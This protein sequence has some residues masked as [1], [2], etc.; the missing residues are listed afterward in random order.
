MT[1]PRGL[2]KATNYWNNVEAWRD[3]KAL[4]AKAVDM[5]MAEIVRKYEPT[6]DAGWRRIDKALAKLR[7]E[8]AKVS[9]E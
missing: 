5:G 9:H 4:S 8:L 2:I 7:A 1:M 3:W 6:P